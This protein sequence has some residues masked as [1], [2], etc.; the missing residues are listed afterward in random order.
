MDKSDSQDRARPHESSRRSNIDDRLTVLTDIVEGMPEADLETYLLRVDGRTLRE[1]SKEL[2]ISK[3]SV[4]SQL[5]HAKMHIRAAKDAFDINTDDRSK[6]S[7]SIVGQPRHESVSSTVQPNQL[8]EGFPRIWS[9][10]PFL[11]P[12]SVRERVY[13]PA[14]NEL[15]E[16]YLLLRGTR[17][18]S[19]DRRW[20]CFCFSVRTAVLVAQCLKAAGGDKA[21]R[22]ARW[23]IAAIVGKRAAEWIREIL[24]P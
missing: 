14:L 5:Y 12:H 1:I 3:S 16:D 20:L 17:Q 18:A 6:A 19:W 2:G 21:W 24:W 9:L 22:A 4:M 11:L 23:V 13:E 15:L 10:F 7:K 8:S